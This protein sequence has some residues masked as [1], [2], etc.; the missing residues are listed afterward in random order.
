M[1]IS[2]NQLVLQ[3]PNTGPYTHVT[4]EGISNSGWIAGNV[5]AQFPQIGYWWPSGP[6]GFKTFNASFN[7]IQEPTWVM[8]IAG[9][10]QSGTQ[11]IVGY[12]AAIVNGVQTNRGFLQQWIPGS[13]VSFTAQDIIDPNAGP[14][15][16][17]KPDAI[18]DHGEIVGTYYANSGGTQ[19][20][21]GF[22]RSSTGAWST[23]SDPNGH[24]GTTVPLGINNAGTIV[25]S[26]TGS[27]NHTH[28][29]IYD[30]GSWTTVSDPSGSDTTVT[31]INDYGVM[32]GYFNS[33]LGTF[34][35]GF[36]YNGV[37]FTNVTPFRDGNGNN[38][39]VQLND[40]NNAGQIAGTWIDPSSGGVAFRMDL[41]PNPA[42]PAG[43][44]AF[45]VLNRGIDYEIYDLGGNA[46]KAAYDLEQIATG[47]TL[48]GV[49]NFG[50]PAGSDGMLRDTTLGSGSGNLMVV[51][52]QNNNA[53]GHTIIGKVGLD[54]RGGGFGDFNGDGYTDMMLQ[55]VNSGGLEAYNIGHNAIVGAAYMGVTGLDWKVTGFGD[56]YS[57]GHDDMLM[58]NVNS[59][60][61]YI[62]DISGNRINSAN[63]IGVVG[64]D[65]QTLGFGNFSGRGNDDMIM[66]NTHTGGLEVYD[67]DH[68]RL[69]GAAF[70]G[71]VGLDW[72]FAGI[73]PVHSANESDLVLRNVTT[74]QF[75]V[76]DIQNNKLVGAAP[77]GAVG[78]DWHVAAFAANPAAFSGAG[79]GGGA[80]AGAGP[81]VQAMASFGA[82][83]SSD[84]LGAVVP[85]ETSQ[86]PLL[87]TPQHA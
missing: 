62:Y 11:S 15:G 16:F 35:T 10:T 55:N 66:R 22:L 2:T 84:G 38:V 58:R 46:I 9:T 44:T 34:S 26:F 41:L 32:T 25:G 45:M 27:D 48:T 20:V 65:W 51:N 17:T 60:G 29:F 42:P 74:G 54:W 85:Q 50:G 70:I 5:S 37:G 12:Y 14:T 57:H 13:T 79:G 21:F 8:D 33:G 87:T 81:L 31:G 77:L 6:G 78:T 4:A 40:I 52:L 1:I 76:Y 36:I 56:F 86:Q 71:T 39:S 67:I 63:Y 24:F 68:G 73:A 43:T 83:G 82:S 72:Q 59:G 75:E 23:L 18:N 61:M 28:G 19:G 69:T 49:G 3:P 80:P 53:I 47:W 7:G 64:T 30:H